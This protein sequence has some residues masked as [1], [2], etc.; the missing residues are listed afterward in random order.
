[1]NL[2]SAIF[3]T[4]MGRTEGGVKTRRP[5]CKGG[6]I[7]FVGLTACG[8]ELEGSVCG[9]GNQRVVLKDGRTITEL[10]VPSLKNARRAFIF[11]ALRDE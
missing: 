3:V 2:R 5:P 10:V 8:W 1:M 11:L 9:F 7:C 6:R 4:L